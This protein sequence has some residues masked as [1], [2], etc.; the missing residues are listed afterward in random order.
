MEKST[1]KNLLE[2]SLISLVLFGLSLIGFAKM[3]E[4]HQLE[5]DQCLAQG[6][7][8]ETYRTIGVFGDKLEIEVDTCKTP[9]PKVT[10]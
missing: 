1:N 2:L 7:V 6:G 5:I 9:T 10:P 4:K 3:A 8:K